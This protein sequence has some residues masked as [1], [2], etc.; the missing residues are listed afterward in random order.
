MKKLSVVK[1]LFN[2]PVVHFELSMKSSEIQI[3]LFNYAHIE[4]Q[5]PKRIN[6]KNYKPQLYYSKNNERGLKHYSPGFV[7]IFYDQT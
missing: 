2:K 3:D 4:L 1:T 6:Q 7:I 5:T